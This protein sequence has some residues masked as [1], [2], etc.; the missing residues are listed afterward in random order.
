MSVDDGLRPLF[1]KHIARCHWQSVETGGTGRG[2]PDSNYC[3]PPL[4]EGYGGY[5]GWIEYKATK[6]YEVSLRPEQIGWIMQRGR[7]GGRVWVAVRRRHQGGLRRGLPVD[8]LWLIPG[9]LAMEARTS[10]LRSDAVQKS[11]RRWHG[12]PTAGWDWDAVAA[13]LRTRSFPD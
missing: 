6:G 9:G 7:A 13:L 3:L 10:G 11:A 2:I 12:G 1:R 5:E 8:E 4:V